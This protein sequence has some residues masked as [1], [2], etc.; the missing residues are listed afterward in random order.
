M[1]E[2]PQEKRNRAFEAYKAR[3]PGQSYA[4]WLHQAAVKHVKQGLQHATLGS[5]LQ[6]TDDWW[7]AGRVTFNRYLK[8]AAIAPDAKVVDYGCGSL[9]VGG[10]FIRHLEPGHYYGLDVTTDLIEAG[11]AMIG[12][13]LLVEK[14]P[15]FGPIDA[16]ALKKAAA[17]GAD[18]VISTAV[19]YHV[20]PEEA[21]V[22]FDN[23]RQLAKKPGA[24]VLFDASISDT[25]TGEHALSKP[26]D[27]F[28]QALAPLEFVNFHVAVERNGEAIGILEFLQPQKAGTLRKLAAKAVK[29]VNTAKKSAAPRRKRP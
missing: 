19:C 22:Y 1:E 7:D 13:A 26:I 9:R 10:H 29:T 24:R 6:N 17:F 12:D 3:N 14:A 8:L 16:A 2:T 27:Y 18:Y 28:V 21:P 15:Q 25:P 5:N 20:Y 23:L 4:Q 11:K